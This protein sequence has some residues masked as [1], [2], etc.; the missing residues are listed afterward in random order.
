MTTTAPPGLVP[1][2]L[3]AR[4]WLEPDVVGLIVDGG[5]SLTFGR[6]DQRS[7]AFARGLDA[8][9]V[10][11]GELIGLRFDG[12]RWL[13]FAVAIFGTMKAGAV[14]VP[15]A[16]GTE[17]PQIAALLAGYGGRAL[18]CPS[19][20]V[21]TPFILPTW[22][23]NEVEHGQP[24]DP[25]AARSGPEG[26][27]QILVTSGTTGQA[28]GVACSHANLLYGIVTDG[29]DLAEARTGRVA[30]HALPIGAN[31]AQAELTR[32]AHRLAR[33]VLMPAFDPERCAA[34][35]AELRVTA[36]L[37]VPSMA[38]MMLNVGALDRHDC[39]SVR[40]LRLTGAPSPPSLLRRLASALPRAQIT[41]EYALTESMPAAVM[42]TY[43]PA[44]PTSVG[45]A[46][47]DELRII[48]D[49]LAS[50]PPGKVGE[51]WLA[52]PGAPLRSYYRDPEAT[53]KVFTG[54]WVRTGDLGYLDAEGY[55]FLTDRKADEI[56]TGARTVSSLEVEA[57]LH[58]CAAVDEA[59]VF[60]LPHDVLGQ[61]VAVAVALHRPMTAAQLKAF[62]RQRLPAYA[63]PQSVLFV[64]R[65]PRTASGKV[66]KHELA[67]RLSAV[68]RRDPGRPRTATEARMTSIWAEMLGLEEEA[69]GLADRFVDLG[70]QS[71]S[72]FQMIVEVERC[73][74]VTLAPDVLDGAETV[75][76]LA[77]VVDA[78]VGGGVQKHDG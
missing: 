46:G 28:K 2:V 20:L 35:V 30:L 50:C 16:A 52:R 7:N 38:T 26:L 75:M 41:N 74:G 1:D 32:A 55:L 13:D 65:L 47:P 78:S 58:E 6:W 10:R 76:A 40:R 43:D 14:A 25:Y 24:D 57:V 27:A 51:V 56:I 77:A 49:S 12:A 18:C 31:A 45:R 36:L 19:D 66:L 5:G 15:F 33:M 42:T 11:P 39:S 60:G 23:T 29:P 71:I 9:G 44:R 34:V 37:L 48:D 61:S 53:A 4:A 68:P 72:A 67:E 54:G 63:V 17:P 8:R 73:Y 59:A 22:D 70:G 69:V 62:A 3:T 21:P 64:D